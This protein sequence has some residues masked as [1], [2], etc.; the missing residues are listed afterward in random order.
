MLFRSEVQL[1]D[2]LNRHFVYIT[3]NEASATRV[4]RQFVK[5]LREE[6]DVHIAH[7]YN[8][9]IRVA[10]TNTVFFFM[11]MERFL[12]RY[13]LMGTKLDR[14][15]VDISTYGTYKQRTQLADK[16]MVLRSVG[17]EII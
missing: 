12:H 16:L 17:A 15:F 1:C 5:L 3:V 14:I 4:C 13:V 8:N 10:E 6:A 9:E 11:G 7:E 2:A